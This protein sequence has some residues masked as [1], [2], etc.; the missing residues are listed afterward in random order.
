MASLLWAWAVNIRAFLPVVQRNVSTAVVG[1][2]QD[3]L[4][5]PPIT[6]CLP[7]PQKSPFQSHCPPQIP[8]LDNT[9]WE[10]ESPK[11][12]VGMEMSLR[13]AGWVATRGPVVPVPG[14][15]TRHKAPS[16]PV[17]GGSALVQSALGERSPQ[18]PDQ[19]FLMEK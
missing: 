9:G 15:A 8:H 3:H 1:G 4:P 19:L 13:G 17:S 2:T 7:S 12:V 11:P 14:T 10:N 6:S 5:P 16:V 18:L